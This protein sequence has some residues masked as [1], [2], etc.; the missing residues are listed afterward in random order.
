MV[1]S[2]LVVLV[3]LASCFLSSSAQSILDVTVGE[4]YTAAHTEGVPPLLP[5]TSPQLLYSV[6]PSDDPDTPAE[7]IESDAQP[8]TSLVNSAPDASCQLV[9]RR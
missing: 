8:R 9:A 6:A 1:A 2:F 4:Q 5:Q 3:L 7:Q